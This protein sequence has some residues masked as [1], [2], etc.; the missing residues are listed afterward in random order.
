MGFTRCIVPEAN[1]TPDDAP[2]GLELVAVR[3]VNEALD[4]LMD[5]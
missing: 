2:S 1:Y 3:T 5:C 4:H